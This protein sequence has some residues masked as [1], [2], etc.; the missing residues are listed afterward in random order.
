MK[1]IYLLLAFVFVVVSAP[2][3][4]AQSVQ[5]A[6]PRSTKDRILEAYAHEAQPDIASKQTNGPAPIVPFRSE[7]TEEMLVRKLTIKRRPPHDPLERVTFLGTVRDGSF[8]SDMA[9]R[10]GAWDDDYRTL[11]SGV[12]YTVMGHSVKV[13][14]QSRMVIK[15]GKRED[16]EISWSGDS[17]GEMKSV[18]YVLK[19]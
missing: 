4:R 8:L 1:T 14:V 10:I 11:R 7:A 13:Y 17:G 9:D 16:V 15:I 18:A 19:F 3:L 5:S 12:D 2:D 6:P